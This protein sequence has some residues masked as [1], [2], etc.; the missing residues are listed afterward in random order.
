MLFRYVISSP[1]CV[2]TPPV[3]SGHRLSLP[4]AA[5]S[6]RA[7][8]AKRSGKPRRHQRACSERT[9]PDHIRISWST[10]MLNVESQE[11]MNP[12]CIREG[13]VN[14]GK[15]PR[16]FCTWISAFSTERFRASAGNTQRQSENRTKQKQ[17][18]VGVKSH[19]DDMFFL[20]EP[21][22]LSETSGR[23]PYPIEMKSER[24]RNKM[25]PSIYYIYIQS[26]QRNE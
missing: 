9:R 19:T 12:A 16:G 3:R 1:L 21:P 8:T 18:G 7:C 14:K 2:D 13:F 11:N 6:Q 25:E 15:P 10:G 20:P 24:R 22:C 17:W 5:R 23:W 4:G 26:P